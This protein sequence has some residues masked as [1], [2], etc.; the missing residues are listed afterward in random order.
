MKVGDLGSGSKVLLLLREECLSSSARLLLE[1][2][3]G[4]SEWSNS[5]SAI[6]LVKLWTFLGCEEYPHCLSSLRDS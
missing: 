5:D 6:Y 4:V 2:L 3:G 1:I